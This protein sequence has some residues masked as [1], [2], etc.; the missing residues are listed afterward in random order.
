MLAKQVASAS[1]RMARSGLVSAA[2]LQLAIGN[3]FAG[4]ASPNAK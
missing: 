3:T 4:A 1:L 2:I